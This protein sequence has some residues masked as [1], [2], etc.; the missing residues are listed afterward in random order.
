MAHLDDF[1]RALLAAIAALLLTAIVGSA[2]AERTYE[3]ADPALFQSWVADLRVEA[4]ENGIRADVFDA[5]FDGMELNPR[6]IELDRRQPEF[7]QTFQEYMNRRVSETRIKRGLEMMTKHRDEL[8]AVADAYGVQPRFIAAIWGM[9]TNYGSYTGGMSVVQSL[10]TLAF[11]PR[12]SAFF[13]KEL[14]AALKILNDGHVQPDAMLGSWGGAMG[15][16]QFMPSSFFAYA[17]DFS[18]DGK[19]DIWGTTIDV[20]ASIANY[21]KRHGWRDD[22]TWGRGVILPDDFSTQE[23]A[24]ARL[25]DARG[26]RAT[27]SHSR[28]LKLSEWQEMG[29]RRLNL[30]D[31]PDRDIE[32]WLVRPAGPDGPAFLAYHNFNRILN[33]NCANYYAMAVGHLADQLKAGE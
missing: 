18:G 27:R 6:V 2:A 11:D 13:R 32:A 9:E 5:A 20:F 10:A 31:L 1:S 23:E 8:R 30:S 12:R 25:P 7:T 29:V 16:S 28:P 24:I 4:L 14:L 22:L 19:A 33:Y 3:D 15:H 26:C 21:L 17:E